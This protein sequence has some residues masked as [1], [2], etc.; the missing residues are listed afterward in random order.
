MNDSAINTIQ[1]PVY[2]IISM[3]T[4]L[5][6]LAHRMIKTTHEHKIIEYPLYEILFITSLNI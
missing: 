5:P 3:N 1:H 4:W 6:V 2:G